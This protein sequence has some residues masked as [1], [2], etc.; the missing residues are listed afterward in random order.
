MRAEFLAAYRSH[1]G[2]EVS[3]DRLRWQEG[4]QL[5][6]D[7]YYFHKRRHLVP[8]FE[9]ELERLVARAEQRL[10]SST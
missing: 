10:R 8:G 3:E 2:S 4:V 7:A 9:A 5:L 1:S 6:Y